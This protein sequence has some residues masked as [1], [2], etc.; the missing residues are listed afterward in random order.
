MVVYVP[1][2][3]QQEALEAET[4]AHLSTLRTL[5]LATTTPSVALRAPN[6]TVVEYFEWASKEAITTAHEHPEVR[7]MWG[8]YEACCTFGSLAELPNASDLFA[9]FELIGSF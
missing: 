1:K 5:G 7:D 6:G 8:R 2:P 4:A 3:G 9:E